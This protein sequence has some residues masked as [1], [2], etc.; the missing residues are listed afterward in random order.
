[1]I[2]LTVYRKLE[3]SSGNPLGKQDATV[4]TKALSTDDICTWFMT[5]AV[6]DVFISIITICRECKR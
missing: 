1:M 6:D 3:W 4:D 5:L 2:K